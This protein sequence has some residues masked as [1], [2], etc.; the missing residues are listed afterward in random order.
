MKTT[1]KKAKKKVAKK[2]SKSFTDLPAT[3]QQL[4]RNDYLSYK[5]ISEISAKYDIPRTSLDY[6]VKKN[7]FQERELLRSELFASFAAG[8]QTEFVSLSSKSL[9]ILEKGLGF[10]ANRTEPPSVKEMGQVAKIFES[11]DKIMRLEAG[12]PTSITIEKPLSIK[13]IKAQ[14]KSADP[15]NTEEIEVVEFSEN[16]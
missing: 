12:D 7:W 13:D 2:V 14:L 4:I 3:T 8:K 9:T 15:F 5:T 10:L 11:L 1:K 6:H 16:D